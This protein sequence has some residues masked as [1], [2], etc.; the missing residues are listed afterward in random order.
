MIS[1]VDIRD[2]DRVDFKAIRESID[3]MDDYA[4]MAGINPFGAYNYLC[5]T[6]DILEQIKRR[7]TKHIPA[8]EKK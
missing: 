6:I 4:R 7:Q 3:N 1:E 8:L 5:Q 2:W